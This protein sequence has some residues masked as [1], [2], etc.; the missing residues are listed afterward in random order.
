MLRLRYYLHYPLLLLLYFFYKKSKAKEFIYSDLIAL[1]RKNRTCYG[2]KQMLFYDVYFK[3]L[4]YKRL[5]KQGYYLK[6]IYRPKVQFEICDNVII[7]KNFSYSH[8]FSTIINAKSI[9]DNF[10]I[11]QNTTIGN[12]IDGRNDLVPTIGD[13]V[14]IGANS[15]VIGNVT[16]GSNVIIGAGTVVVKDVPDNSIVVGNPARI[17]KYNGRNKQ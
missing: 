9:G 11:H 12:K 3:V 8:P 5:G 2:I 16:I 14:S 6:N 7:G 13:N 15:C 1:N 10:T 17:L 4:F